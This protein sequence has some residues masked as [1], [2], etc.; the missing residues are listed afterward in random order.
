MT[1]EEIVPWKET[2]TKSFDKTVLGRTVEI[3]H[4]IPAKNGMKT[5]LEGKRGI[6]KVQALEKHHGLEKRTDFPKIFAKFRQILSFECLGYQPD[7]FAV[8][9]TLSGPL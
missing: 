5:V 7:P 2:R 8:V 1:D 4:D 9:L 6:H 3:D